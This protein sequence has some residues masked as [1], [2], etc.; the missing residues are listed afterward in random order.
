LTA[1]APFA[2]IP[3]HS[4]SDI[5]NREKDRTPVNKASR[6]IAGAL[7]TL[8]IVSRIAAVWV[9]QSHHVPRS[10]YE[11][12]EIAANLLAG[13]GFTTHFLGATGPTSQQAPIYPALVAL[14]FAAAGVETPQALL[15]LEL[16][17]SILGGVLVLGVLMLAHS[18]APGR[19]LLAFIAGLVTALH[20]TLIY[21]ATHVQ[22]A[23][24][25]T[26]FFI[27]TLATAYKTGIGRS[28]RA[29]AVTGVLLALLALTDPILALAGAGVAWAVCAPW[30]AHV[31]RRR[32]I[33]LLTVIAITA[34]AG[35]TPWLLRNARVHGEFVAIKSTFGYAFWQGNCSLS[36]GT[37]KV[38]RRSVEQV[39]DRNQS[40]PGFEGLN[41]KLWEARHEAGYIDDIALS[42]QDY[43]LLGRSSEPER[44][45]ILFK[46]A[47][48]ELKT[49]PGRYI[50][51]CLRRLRYFILFDETNPKSRVLAYRAPHLALSVFGVLGLLLAGP[52][53]RSRLLPTIATA[54]LIVIF[55]TLTIVSARFH[56]PIE[57]LLGLW[58]AAGLLG[59]SDVLKRWRSRARTNP[60]PVQPPPPHRAQSP[61]AVTRGSR[62]RQKRP[63][64][65]PACH[66]S[67]GEA[68]Q[69][70]SGHEC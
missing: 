17:Q 48:E 29:A 35:V 39:L 36:E 41:R 44:S 7:V 11:H 65:K 23:S 34:L 55:H 1:I 49:D 43:L 62:P 30:A 3:L 32:P 24:L 12:G 19:P 46:R 64:Q 54:G 20:P 56:I 45:R 9:L 66:S 25:G 31:D 27:W 22:V 59:A 58:G 40:A 4:A 13:K 47:L 38:V 33:V 10:T 2:R 42:K 63:D 15:L 60:R 5:G 52:A 14:A 51:L 37:D 16:G 26:T 21:A 61:T 53:L 18:I 6:V 70:P 57:P 50:R 67:S 8:A 69:S 28:F 68:T